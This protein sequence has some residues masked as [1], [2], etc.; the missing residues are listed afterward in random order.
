[1]QTV[2]L[3]EQEWQALINV[4]ANTREHPWVITNPLL[5]KIGQQ[6]QEQTPVNQMPAQ[7]QD[8]QPFVSKP[9][10]SHDTETSSADVFERERGYRQPP[11]R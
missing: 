11:G 8:R 5:M 10:N 2:T 4:L 3:A 7:L 1:M 9:G 6:L